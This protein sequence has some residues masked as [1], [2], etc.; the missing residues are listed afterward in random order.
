VTSLSVLIFAVGKRKR[1]KLTE[2]LPFVLH[3]IRYSFAK[4]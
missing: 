2:W 4:L 3:Y 1:E